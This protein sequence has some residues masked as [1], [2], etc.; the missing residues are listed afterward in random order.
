MG[1]HADV[2]AAIV[3]LLEAALPEGVPVLNGLVEDE[4]ARHSLNA[5]VLI[6]RDSI[7]MESHA[8]IN[9]STTADTQLE[10]WEWNLIVKGGGGAATEPDKG[11]E[12]DLI[13]ETIRTALNAQRPTTDCGPL[14]IL[15]EEYY[16]VIGGGV[17]YLQRWRH[18]RMAG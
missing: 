11:A 2:Q 13:L 7:R 16:D 1:Y 18:S 14:S 5:F 4:A 10:E 15:S 3:A 6:G 12:V 9:P 17:A 8:E